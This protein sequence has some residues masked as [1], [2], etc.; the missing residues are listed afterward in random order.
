MFNALWSMWECVQNRLLENLVEKFVFH[1]GWWLEVKPSKTW[2]KTLWSMWGGGQMHTSS[3]HDRIL[4]GPFWKG[5]RGKGVKNVIRVLCGQC[6]EVVRINI[7]WL[8][9]VVF[10]LCIAYELI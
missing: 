6:R 1:V 8:Q 10:P 7:L 3:K 4:C 9:L 2:F 5:V